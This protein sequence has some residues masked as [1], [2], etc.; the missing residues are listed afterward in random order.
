MDGAVGG[1]E[2]GEKKHTKN[3]K[4][5]LSHCTLDFCSSIMNISGDLDLL[6]FICDTVLILYTLQLFRVCVSFPPSSHLSPLS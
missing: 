1:G 4:S 2:G 5:A 6:A 3:R